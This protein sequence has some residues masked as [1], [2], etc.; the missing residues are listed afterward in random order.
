M[1]KAAGIVLAGLILALAGCAWWI[2]H[3]VFTWAD[4]IQQLADPGRLARLDMPSSALISSCDP[5]G[6]NDDFN[7]FL[8]PGRTPG[9]VVLADLRGPGY[10]TRFWFTGAEPDHPLRFYFD[11]ESV[12]RVITTLG[13]YCGGQEPGLAPLAAHQNYCW[14]SFVPVPYQK[15]L[16][17]ET[18]GGGQQPDGWPR[19]FYQINYASLPRGQS[20]ESL[21]RAPTAEDLAAA[22][23]VR[24]VWNTSLFQRSYP[25]AAAQVTNGLLAAGAARELWQLAGPGLIREFWFEPELASLSSPLAREQLLRE[26]ILRIHWDHSSAA[27]VAVPLGDLCGSCWQRTRFQ[28]L[29]FGLTNN[30]FYCGFPMPFAKAARISIEN[31]GSQEIAFRAGLKLEPLAEWDAA[32]GYFHS[33]W[34]RTTPAEVG[35]P[36]PV[37]RVQGRGKYVGCIMAVASL[38]RSYWILEGDELIRKDNEKTPGWRGTGLEDYFNGGWYYQNV[39]AGPLHGL[40]YKAPF[41]TVQYSL[42]LMNPV[43]FDSAL[44]LEFERGPEHASRGWMESVAFYYLDQPSSAYS[45]LGSPALRREPVDNHLAPAVLMTELWNY[46]RFGDHQGASEYIERYLERYPQFPFAEILR[47]R[48]LAYRERTEGFTAIRPHYAE[49]ANTATN[50]LARQMAETLLWYHQNPSNALLGAYANMRTKIFLDGQ[51]IGESG[52]PERMAVWRVQIGPGRHVLA[53]QAPWQAYPDWTQLI[54]RT[55]QGDIRTATQWKH[56]LNP[57]AGW[58]ALDYDDGA[59]VPLA[60]KTKGPPEEP[61]IW[62]MPD[63]YVDMQSQADGLRNEHPW[64]DHRGSVVYRT[65]FE[66]P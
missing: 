50:S 16:I 45:Q 12:P 58:Q 20:V 66:L 35:A 17:I 44:E 33:G 37:L 29:Y 24:E 30:V 53:M 65:V 61:Y 32:W 8:R 27:S 14:F 2:P 25:A 41:R 28:S 21:P 62:V 47:L 56:A 3:T 46:E 39:M 42:H 7:N 6:G 51:E 40:P 13:D 55:H 48:Q 57:P 23:R 60:H 63:P 5:T 9:W 22:R 64:P 59:W 49:L 1:K 26:L 19:L 18:P 4:L 34:Q 31:Q 36:H 38:D 11:G 43:L 10:M 54:L 15:R 52:D